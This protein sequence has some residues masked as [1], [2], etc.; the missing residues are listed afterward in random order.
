[1]SFRYDIVVGFQHKSE[2]EQFLKEMRTRF[3]NFILELHPDKTRLIRFGRFADEDQKKGGGKKPETFDFLGFTHIC[4]KTRKG[5]FRVLR[6]TMRNRLGA[7]LK[8]VK[9]ELRR[10][11]HEP[12]PKVGMWSRSVDVG[13]DGAL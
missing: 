1:M 2:A 7:K 13:S 3:R 9:L 11:M 4:G 5:K 12:V 8:E 6:R 10:R